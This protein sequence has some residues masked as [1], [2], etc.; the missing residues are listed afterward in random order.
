MLQYIAIS[1]ISIFLSGV[2]YCIAVVNIAIY[3]SI[4]CNI[5]AS[6]V[7]MCNNFAL[8]QITVNDLDFHT[9][10]SL[11]NLRTEEEMCMYPPRFKVSVVRLS[12]GKELDTEFKIVLEN[13]GILVSDEV[14]RFTLTVAK[15]DKRGKILTVAIAT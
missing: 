3:R 8:I 10:S 7:P 1:N 15:L 5:V 2:L 14:R 9:Y 11:E 4:Y 13:D 6:L 12:H